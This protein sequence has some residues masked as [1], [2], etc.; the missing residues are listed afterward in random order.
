MSK[1][2]TA[3]RSPREGGQ[4]AQSQAKAREDTREELKRRVERLE[5]RS[6][7][8]EQLAQ[9][10]SDQIY[11]LHGVIGALKG[12]LEALKRRAEEGEET[13]SLGPALDPPPHY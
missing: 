13:P 1:Q 3:K 2:Q 7:F 6:A 8:Q 9:E 12:E 11:E 4:G 10:L 5:V